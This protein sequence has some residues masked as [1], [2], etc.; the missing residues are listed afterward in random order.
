MAFLTETEKAFQWLS[1][2]K[3]G[4]ESVQTAAK[5]AKER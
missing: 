4:A 5:K 1:H 2:V 3:D